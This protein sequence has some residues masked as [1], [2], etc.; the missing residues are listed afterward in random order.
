MTN[1]KAI[2]IENVA[3]VSGVVE[4]SCANYERMGFI[5]TPVS[6]HYEDGDRDKQHAN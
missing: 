2:G 3:V 5:L 1:L 4:P 6:A